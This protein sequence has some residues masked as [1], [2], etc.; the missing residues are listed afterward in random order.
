MWIED[1]DQDNEHYLR[2]FTDVLVPGLTTRVGFNPH[3]G[4]F[5]VDSSLN[6]NPVAEVTGSMW[7]INLATQFRILTALGRAVL[8]A[9]KSPGEVEELENEQKPRVKKKRRRKK[10]NKRS[11]NNRAS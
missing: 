7:S 4:A 3:T 1:G 11:G 5:V 8:L 9:E 6:G 2:E 10:K